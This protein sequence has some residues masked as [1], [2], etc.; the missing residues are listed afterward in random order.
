MNY[1]DLARYV[2]PFAFGALLTLVI[3]VLLPRPTGPQD[4]DVCFLVNDAKEPVPHAEVG[5]RFCVRRQSGGPW[6]LF[7]DANMTDW[8]AVGGGTE[9]PLELKYA[10]G[11]ADWD[12]LRFDFDVEVNPHQNTTHNNQHKK[13][14]N[15]FKLQIN[16]GLP[17]DARIRGFGPPG[18]PIHGGTAHA[19][20]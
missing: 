5:D 16:N 1:R 4:F 7:P 2:I 13:P 19:E 6:R 3:T 18:S 20:Q 9:I 11:N 15:G 8:K 14:N 12:V 17:M 10:D